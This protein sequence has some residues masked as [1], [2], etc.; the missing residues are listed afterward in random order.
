M[1]TTTHSKEVEEEEPLWQAHELPAATAMRLTSLRTS[2]ADLK[3]HLALELA[4]RDDAERSRANMEA[5]VNSGAAAEAAADREVADREPVVGPWDGPGGGD[6]GTGGGA[7]SGGGGGLLEVNR[8]RAR[9]VG[10]AAARLDALVSGERA[11]AARLDKDVKAGRKKLREEGD[12]GDKAAAAAAAA[13][14]AAAKAR[15]AVAIAKSKARETAPAVSRELERERASAEKRGESVDAREG[16]PG[17]G[18]VATAAAA[19]KSAARQRAEVETAEAAM[20]E[21]G[22]ELAETRREADRGKREH[23]EAEAAAA[24]AEE[25]MAA[26]AQGS[27]GQQ[28][29]FIYAPLK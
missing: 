19:A 2:I 25:N 13:K 12:R 24:R 17:A 9:G 16:A 8:A 15:T 7:Y 11:R 26:A 23:R 6:E 28:V 4:R 27:G 5:A 10:E 3:R 1:T 21:A 18:G 29:G 20:G 22:R 14:G